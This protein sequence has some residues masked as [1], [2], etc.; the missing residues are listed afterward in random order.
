MVTFS[1]R[2]SDIREPGAQAIPTLPDGRNLGVGLT[3]LLEAEPG[4]ISVN[5]RV[6]V[7]ANE[8]IEQIEAPV[9]ITVFL[10]EI[11]NAAPRRFRNR[12]SPNYSSISR[13][14][15][16]AIRR[17]EFISGTQAPAPDVPTGVARTRIPGA[18]RQAPDLSD[19]FEITGEILEKINA[20]NDITIDMSN[21][22][23]VGDLSDINLEVDFAGRVFRRLST[24][25][26]RATSYSVPLRYTAPTIPN[27]GNV[28]QLASRIDVPLTIILTPLDGNIWERGSFTGG[29]LPWPTISFDIPLNALVEFKDLSEFS[30][31][32]LLQTTDV[33]SQVNDLKTGARSRLEGLKSDIS[34]IES[35][36]EDIFSRT[37]AG[38]GGAAG[39][40]A[41]GPIPTGFRG[42]R[43]VGG[44]GNESISDLLDTARGLEPGTVIQ[45]LPDSEVRDFQRRLGN[46]NLDRIDPDDVINN[47]QDLLDTIRGSIPDRCVGDLEDEINDV[48][49]RAR[50]IRDRIGTARD[51]KD[52]LEE[53]LGGDLPS[54]E[55]ISDA[56]S[57]ISSDIDSLESDLPDEVRR[58]VE[59]ANRPGQLPEV[60][61]VA[62]VTVNGETFSVSGQAGGGGFL[63]QFGGRARQ[64][65]Q[66][67]AQQAEQAQRQIRNRLDNLESSV[68]DLE[69][70][71]NRAS[72]S[73]RC[74]E[75]LSGR[76]NVMDSALQRARPGEAEIPERR[77][78][79]EPELTCSDVSSGLRSRVNQFQR[80]AGQFSGLPQAQRREDRR[81]RLVSQGESIRSDIQSDVSSDNPC[82]SE[83]L[84]RVDAQLSNLRGVGT[85]LPS[86]VPCSEKFPTIEGQVDVYVRRT[87]NLTLPASPQDVQRL[88]RQG[89][90]LIQSV[91][92]DV[93]AGD[94]CREQFADQIRSALD[95]LESATTSV[96]V[97][98]AGEDFQ[99]EQQEQL[100]DLRES[101][102]LIV[103]QPTLQFLE[104][105]T[106]EFV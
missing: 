57:S 60:I 97:V 68:S 2:K 67:A 37:G 15:N 6:I 35:V 85:R 86:Q 99:Q 61:G 18:Q 71:V 52:R 77:E 7:Q 104:G 17:A 45:N 91:Q 65:A 101:V 95:R 27:I 72:L 16:R 10:G 4:E 93:D 5:G 3:A 44:G 62:S 59:R 33:Q 64:T 14:V 39:S 34:T 106:S 54:C 12:N 76:L 41:G 83:L 88:S 32:E 81:S 8:L 49:R 19:A 25:D 55:E 50:S 90:D 22:P 46:T 23:V 9:T 40:A 80:Q 75:A 82:K 48:L 43:R 84:G 26:V 29:T 21:A 79:P 31:S 98:E 36:A 28:E 102:Q 94:P 58:E 20:S 103:E 24:A 78:P 42:L 66:D 105:D 87:N 96:R 92:D 74:E 30:C 69:S 11:P 1:G 38:G 51:L 70:R 47:A 73:Q 56:F 100:S 53:L 89:A 63:G 13:R